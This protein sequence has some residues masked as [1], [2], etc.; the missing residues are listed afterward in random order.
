MYNDYYQE[1]ELM[2]SLSSFEE[3]LEHN[4]NKYFEIHE[5]EYI[6]DHYLSSG[7]I[8]GSRK[9]IQKAL[10]IHTKSHELQKRLAQL[11]NMEGFHESAIEILNTSFKSFGTDK[12]IDYYLILGESYL[13]IGK[14]EKAKLAFNKAIEIS[15][16][17]F[18]DIVTA[19]ASLYQQ[20][21]YFEEVVKHLK[22]IEK[23]DAS[24]LF[25]IGLSYHNLMDYKNAI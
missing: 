15:E 10:L 1:E 14:A 17:E 21:G 6:I 11:N 8:S 25:D 16:D 22:S 24:L 3:A 4:E 13:G 2:G 19:V 18:F 7:D 12:D 5:F 9:A 23:E 20:E